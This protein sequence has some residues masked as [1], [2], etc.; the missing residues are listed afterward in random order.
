M[1]LVIVLL[2]LALIGAAVLVLRSRPGPGGPVTLLSLVPSQVELIRLDA[3]GQPPIIVRQEGHRR[4]WQI[5]VGGS[6]GAETRWPASEARVRAAL[7]VLSALSGEASDPLPDAEVGT[8][9]TIVSGDGSEWRLRLAAQSLAGRGRIRV[10]SPAGDI[11]HALVDGDVHLML[12][13]QGMMQWRDTRAVP[14]FDGTASRVSAVA[15]SSALRLAT[16]RGRW[17]MRDPIIAPAEPRIVQELLRAIESLTVVRFRDDQPAQTLDT[18]S[19]VIELESDIPSPTDDERDRRVLVRRLSV[20][21]PA[22]A[23]GARYLA[24]AESLLLTPHSRATETLAGPVTVEVVAEALG[25]LPL[26]PDA[27]IA[28]RAITVPAADV[29][30][31]QMGALVLERT[32]DGWIRL[33][34]ERPEP[35][36]SE[37]ADGIEAVLALL[38]DVPADVVLQRQENPIMGLEV[39]ASISLRA[40]DGS[41]LGSFT[42]GVAPLESAD[43]ER[44]AAAVVL[45]DSI[46]RYYQAARSRDAIAWLAHHRLE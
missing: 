40:I 18:P 12:A 25:A 46:T 38:A 26:D 4:E 5:V 17:G 34:G 37:H 29:G 30:R 9:V 24:R 21:G 13:W 27:F 19:L 2:S 45:Q 23:A 43:G 36:P 10:E 44:T 42:I 3:P 31:F 32:L 16:V 39:L 41:D 20:L 7:R 8:V 1:R 6:D 22:D 35:L 15:G 14:G 11:V 33:D 28:R